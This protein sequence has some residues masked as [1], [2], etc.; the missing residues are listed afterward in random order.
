[1]LDRLVSALLEGQLRGSSKWAS[2]KY[3]FFGGPT[4]ALFFFTTNGKEL[5]STPSEK[6][7]VGGL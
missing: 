2:W 7:Q 6:K 3:K 1:V 5:V 4:E